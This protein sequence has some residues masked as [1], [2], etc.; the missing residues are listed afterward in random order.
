MLY[1]LRKNI[2]ASAKLKFVSVFA[3]F[4]QKLGVRF[5][6]M[7]HKR[8]R[9]NPKSQEFRIQ[10]KDSRQFIR[11]QAFFDRVK[12]ESVCLDTVDDVT[13]HLALKF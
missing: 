11:D 9:R 6:S 5:Y 4:T 12:G 7:T 10:L 1:L 3:P 8:G 2:W 13:F